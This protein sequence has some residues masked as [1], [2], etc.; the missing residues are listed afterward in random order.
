VQIV[1][2]FTLLSIPAIILLIVDQFVRGKYNSL[3]PS[4]I[5]T[6]LRT[7]GFVFALI[8]VIFAT[9][10][11]LYFSEI[12]GF[13]PCTLCWYQRIFMY[14]QLLLITLALIK[15][16]RSIAPYLFSLTG[17]GL[18]VALYQLLLPY[19][20]FN[21]V[22]CSTTAVSCTI[23]YVSY[24]GFITIPLMSFISF[25]LVGIFISYTMIRTTTDN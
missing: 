13:A 22:S 14:P 12:A 3:L 21:T 24:F 19:L 18:L 10:G 6:V 1:A 7:Y 4:A 16:D 15:K 25:V 17:I 8:V 5:V 20:P 9:F 11:S 2:F 23:E